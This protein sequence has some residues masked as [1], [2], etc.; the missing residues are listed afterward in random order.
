MIAA[1]PSHWPRLSV[2]PSSTQLAVAVTTGS[3]YTSEASLEVTT[4]WARA[5]G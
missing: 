5:A 2:S 3:V 4:R 1:A